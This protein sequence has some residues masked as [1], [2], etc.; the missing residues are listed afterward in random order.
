MGT[1]EMF[2]KANKKK[3]RRESLMIGIVSVT[4]GM[5]FTALIMSM[6]LY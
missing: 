1:R 5:G 4:M 2:T 6:I 3:M